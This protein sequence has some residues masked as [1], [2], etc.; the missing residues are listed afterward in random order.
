MEQEYVLEKSD[1]FEPEHIFEC[2][3]CFRWNR[4][5]DGSYVGVF[6]NNVVNVRKENNDIVFRGIC[7]GDIKDICTKYFNL[8][9]NYEDV[10]SRLSKVDTYL[11]TSI[12][13]GTGI[14]ILKQDLW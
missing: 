4:E 5:I 7:E 3:Q 1:S 9:Y 13:Y 14:R 8:D 12:Q 11:K 6:G 2:G 10:K